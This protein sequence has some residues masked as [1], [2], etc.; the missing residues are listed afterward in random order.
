MKHR[1]AL[2]RPRVLAPL[3]IAAAFGLS[4]ATLSA[5]TVSAATPHTRTATTATTTARSAAPVVPAGFTEH[6]AAG[7]DYVIGGHGPTLVLLHGYPETWYEW[8]ALLPELSRHYTVIAPSL[9]GAGK[10]DAPADGYDKKSMAA[11]VHT[12]LRGIGHAD[13]IRLVGH[14]IGSMVAY[15]Y[16]AAHPRDVK[17][18]VLSEAPIPDASLYTFP[19]LTAA[20]PAAWNFGFFSLAN[21]LPEK[22]VAGREKEWV[23]GF[24][25]SLEV[26]KGSVTDDDTAVFAEA[27]K[28]PA[29]LSASFK[30]FRTFPQDVEDNAVNRRTKLTM[31]VL[32]VGASG[33][34]GEAVPDQVRRYAKKVTG[35][36]VPDSGHWIYEERPV[37]MTA[38]LLSF[39]GRTS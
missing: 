10:S 25:D 39:L 20:G 37:K 18:I 13:D 7:L 27:L 17:K 9:P 31:P 24:V 6:K 23:G 1:H 38:L 3:A 14:D 4:A 36:V 35:V 8:R 32:A 28:D 5:A 26:R 21:G 12:L 30:W 16:A 29:H 33:S 34:L 2:F 11:T 15:S 19:S 22:V